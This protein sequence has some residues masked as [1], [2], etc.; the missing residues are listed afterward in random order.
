MEALVAYIPNWLL[1][2]CRVSSF[3]MIAPVFSTRGL[4]AQWKVGLSAVLAF[5][6][7]APAGMGEHP[8][9]FDWLYIVSI[10]REILVGLLLGFAAYLFF[11][12]VQIAGAFID[13]QMGLGLA[14]VIDPMTGAQSPIIGNFKFILAM[15]LFLSF[16]GHHL[17]IDGLIRS[18]EWIPLSGELFARIYEGRIHEFL[19]RTFMTVFTLALQMAAPLVV[20]MFLTDIGLGILSK[21]APQFNVFVV[22]VPIK[23]L[24]GI[25]LLLLIIPGFITLFQQLFASMFDSLSQLI[26]LVGANQR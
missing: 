17:L 6:A 25:L 23:L 22:G 21:T 2:F 14:N 3:V 18:Y 1:I 26:Q 20:A 15:L 19:I 7:F 4:P 24:V 11:T 5:L 10:L 16:N 12:A 13:I 8:A 9:E